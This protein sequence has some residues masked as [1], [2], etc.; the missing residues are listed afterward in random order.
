M[1]A[2]SMEDLNKETEKKVFKRTL[3]SITFKNGQPEISLY[4]SHTHR[5]LNPSGKFSIGGPQGDAGLTGRKITIDMHGGWGEYG[6]GAFSGKGNLSVENITNTLMVECD[7][8]PVAIAQFS[9]LREPKVQE[10]AAYCHFGRQP[11]T[12]DGIK[13]FEWENA[14]DLTKYETMESSHVT[15][16]LNSSNCLN[17]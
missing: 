7:S 11:Y 3:Q 12:K 8:Q 2:Q 14:K 17:K 1:T 15:T 16:A 4:G 9:A 13:L 10:T 6:G 5:H